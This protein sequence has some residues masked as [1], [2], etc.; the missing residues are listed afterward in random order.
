MHP[1]IALHIALNLSV[2]ASW[3]Y[4]D[5]LSENFWGNPLTVVLVPFTLYMLRRLGHEHGLSRAARGAWALVLVAAYPLGLGVLAL[6]AW[7][8]GVPMEAFGAALFAV[9]LFPLAHV[10]G[11]IVFNA[12]IRGRMP[13]GAQQALMPA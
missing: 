12:C 6:D 13:R 10:A 9:L 7:W 2:L 1:V 3:M 11:L 4:V 8:I 5:A